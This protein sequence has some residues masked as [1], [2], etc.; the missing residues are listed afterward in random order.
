MGLSQLR[1]WT[2]SALFCSA[3][4]LAS[5]SLALVPIG[6]TKAPFTG[7]NQLKL[8][9][10][11]ELQAVS[12][13]QYRQFLQ[14]SD[15]EN[16]TKLGREVQVIGKRIALAAQVYYESIGDSE[17]LRGY[18]WEFNVVESPE[19]NAFAMAGGKV[20]VFTGLLPIAK[21]ADGLAVV[22]GHEIAHA[23]AGHGNERMSQ[24][25]LAALGGA[26]LAVAMRDSPRETQAALMA[27][28]GAGATVGVLLPF[29]RKH[30]SEADEI[31]LI[32]SSIAGYDPRAAAPLWERMA[33]TG[34]T[35]PEFLST[36]PSPENR[37][38][39]LEA[40]V[41]KALSYA[42]KYGPLVDERLG[43]VKK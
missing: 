1:Q 21:N 26:G 15:V 5:G 3:L 37:A 42:K 43:P 30:E 41:P 8:F 25:A 39:E 20:V 19:A 27:A 6:C 40:L 22:M 9:Q 7:R 23:I 29:S 14:E 31:G 11:S 28:Y 24:E 38:G 16:D 33:K 12:A 10:E 4:T 17:A 36:H 2:R 34:D 35:P 13:T 32:L 18:Q